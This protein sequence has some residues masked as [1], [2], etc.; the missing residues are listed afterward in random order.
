MKTLH[1]RQFR[2]SL[3]ELEQ[4]YNK[5][6]QSK[7][8]A[9]YPSFDMTKDQKKLYDLWQCDAIYYKNLQADFMNELEQ[10]WD[11]ENDC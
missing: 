9:G 1:I 2:K 10:Q 3:I 5:Q 7:E 8:L 4:A 6:K 11:K